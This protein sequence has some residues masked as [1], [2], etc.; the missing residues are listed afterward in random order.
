MGLAL[1]KRIVDRFDGEIW[2]EAAPNGGSIFSFT[3]DEGANSK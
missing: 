2:H 3:V 1:S